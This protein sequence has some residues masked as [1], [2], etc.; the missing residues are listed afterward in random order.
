MLQNMFYNMTQVLQADSESGFLGIGNPKI[1]QIIVF[2]IWGVLAAIGVGVLIMG[3]FKHIQGKRDAE[4]AKPKVLLYSLI[5][6]GLLVFLPFVII[7][8][9]S[10]VETILG[11]AA[12]ESLDFPL[13]GFS[14]AIFG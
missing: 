10:L 6:T 11:S 12:G 5:T 4:K 3:I 8:I 9:I 7:G 2:S 14:E 13:S 1:V